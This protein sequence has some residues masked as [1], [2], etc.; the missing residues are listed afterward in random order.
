VAPTPARDADV[1]F[2]ASGKLLV[3]DS[4][5]TSQQF[6]QWFGSIEAQVCVCVCVCVYVSMSVSCVRVYVCVCVC[7]YA[8]CDARSVP[9]A[10][11][12]PSPHT[13]VH[14]CRW[15]RSTNLLSDSTPSC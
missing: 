4:I 11:H 2:D 7:V 10:R 8:M 12:K 3:T 6:F 13:R 15:S 5:E 9:C 14:A 1:S